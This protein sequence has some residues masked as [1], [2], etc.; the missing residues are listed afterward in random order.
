MRNEN[1]NSWRDLWLIFCRIANW[2]N[3]FLLNIQFHPINHKSL[4][5]EQTLNDM[6]KQYETIEKIPHF[7]PI[8]STIEQVSESNNFSRRKLFYM[9]D[10][11]LN[12]YPNNPFQTTPSIISIDILLSILQNVNKEL[13][14][15]TSFQMNERRGKRSRMTW[16]DWL[17]HSWDLTRR[18]EWIQRMM[19]RTI[20]KKYYNDFISLDAWKDRIESY[21]G[22]NDTHNSFETYENTNPSSHFEFLTGMKTSTNENKP[23]QDSWHLIQDFDKIQY[24]YLRTCEQFQLEK[25]RYEFM[26]FDQ[27]N[28][29]FHTLDQI[30]KSYIYGPLIKDEYY[31]TINKDIFQHFDDDPFM[32]LLS[33]SER[34]EMEVESPFNPSIKYP[35]LK[36]LNMSSFSRRDFRRD[37]LL[38]SIG[39]KDIPTSIS[40]S[41]EVDRICNVLGE[42]LNHETRLTKSR[43]KPWYYH[44]LP[45]DRGNFNDINSNEKQ[46][47][48]N[49]IFPWNQEGIGHLFDYSR[50]S[51]LLQ[52]SDSIAPPQLHIN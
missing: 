16:R 15:D 47:N 13:F 46:I 28:N 30:S 32:L 45:N 38:S 3:K 40:W 9:D 37:L 18:K 2:I 26:T 7:L 1:F 24:V 50:E 12:K 52:R 5:P 10:A 27:N 19:N 39:S 8:N 4:Q 22:I 20:H 31:R 17:V 14:F 49:T 48:R 23:I 25:Q 29:K 36:T 21:F 33:E 35:K 34:R 11:P 42:I 43:E 6:K 41:I 44:I 51:R